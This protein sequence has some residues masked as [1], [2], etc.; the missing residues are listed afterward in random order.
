M[1]DH[2]TTWAPERIWLLRDADGGP[3]QHLWCQDPD[4][5]GDGTE[6]IAYVRLD[7]AVRPHDAEYVTRATYDVLLNAYEGKSVIELVA[8]RNASRQRAEAA[9]AKL[10]GARATQHL[11]AR[12]PETGRLEQLSDEHHSVAQREEF[13]ATYRGIG[14]IEFRLEPPVRAAEG[15]PAGRRPIA[16]DGASS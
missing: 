9:E 10:G 12:N 4:P 15:D 14:W 2:D 11:W 1:T 5:A 7:A 16:R 8:E 13:E 3:G 6:S